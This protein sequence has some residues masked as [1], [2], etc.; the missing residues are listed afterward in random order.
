MKEAEGGDV[1]GV[2]IE[3]ERLEGENGKMG[4]QAREVHIS[5]RTSL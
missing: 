4:K 3:R 2:E 5:E 1:G